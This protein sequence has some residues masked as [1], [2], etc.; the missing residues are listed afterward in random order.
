MDSGC[1]TLRVLPD[2]QLRL[3]FK[4]GSQAIVNMKHR[5]HAI[6][7]GCL[8]MPGLFGTARLEG[9]EVVW[10]NGTCCVRA[11]INELLNSMQMD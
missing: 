8:S 5:V 2:Y 3:D 1:V 9:G 10:D 6:R 4:N 7:F 11:T